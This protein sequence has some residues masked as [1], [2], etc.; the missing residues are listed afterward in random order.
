M[1]HLTLPTDETRR[2]S[3]YL[4]MEEYAARSLSSRGDSEESYFF[5][6]QVEPTV[7]FGRN[8]VIEN[9]V[10]VEYCRKHGIQFYRRKSGGGCVYADKS[11][12]MMSYITRSDEVQTTFSRYMQMVCGMLREL[13][14]EATSTANNDVLIGSRKVSGNAFYHIPGWSIVHGT[15]LFDTDMQ[16]MLNAITPPQQKLDKHGVESV[17]QRITLLK[18]HTDLSIEEFKK[19]ANERLCDKELRLTE[20]D[21]KNIETIEQEYL[22][23]EFIWGT[24]GLK[25]T[26]TT[27]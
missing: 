6:W 24:K 5:L 27:E 19:F 15:M 13:G 22:N 21:V 9:E 17:R 23:P 7:I 1:I 25:E 8:Q 18:E 10:N 2:L 11:N 12:V 16:H 3:F 14:L 4:A 26:T 20:E